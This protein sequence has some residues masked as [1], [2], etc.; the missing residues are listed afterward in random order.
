MKMV[1]LLFTFLRYSVCLTLVLIILVLVS[2][3]HSD[4]VQF[5]IQINYSN[6]KQVLTPVRESL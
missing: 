4:N 2:Q 1:L 3:Q 6:F 5:I